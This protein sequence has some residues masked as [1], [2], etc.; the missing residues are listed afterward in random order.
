MLLCHVMR[1]MIDDRQLATC[2]STAPL[3]LTPS[4][5]SPLDATV[6]VQRLQWPMPLSRSRLQVGLGL[7]LSWALSLSLVLALALALALA[8]LRPS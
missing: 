5:V 1:A 6:S 7:A 2:P 8:R 3:T 4:V